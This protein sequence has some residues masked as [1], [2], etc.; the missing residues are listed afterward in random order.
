MSDIS[1]EEIIDM[2]LDSHEADNEPD[3][4]ESKLKEELTEILK[5]DTYMYI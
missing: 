3:N 1:V 4:F 2:C 5:R